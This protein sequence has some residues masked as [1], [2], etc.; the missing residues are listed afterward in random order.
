MFDVVNVI[1]VAAHHLS[2]TRPG[3]FAD[4]VLSTIKEQIANANTETTVTVIVTEEQTMTIDPGTWALY[5]GAGDLDVYIAAGFLAQI[6]EAVCANMTGTCNARMAD[7]RRLEEQQSEQQLQALAEANDQHPRRLAGST[8]VALTRNYDAA[9]P[10]A[11]V[12]VSTLV[13]ARMAAAG[14]SVASTEATSLSA[15]STVSAVGSTDAMASVIAGLT[16]ASLGA[17]LQQALP[18]VELS[19]VT[20]IQTPPAQPPLPTPPP[21]TPPGWPS[22]PP[23][24]NSSAASAEGNKGE[25]NIMI[26]VLALVSTVTIIGL[27][28]FLCTHAKQ[29]DAANAAAAQQ[30]QQT[31]TMGKTMGANASQEAAPAAAPASDADAGRMLPFGVTS[32]SIVLE[33]A[34]QPPLPVS[35]RQPLA[36]PSSASSLAVTARNLIEASAQEIEIV[37]RMVAKIVSRHPCCCRHQARRAKHHLGA[38]VQSSVATAVVLPRRRPC[39]GAHLSLTLSLPRSSSSPL[40]HTAGLALCSLARFA[41]RARCNGQPHAAHHADRDD[42]SDG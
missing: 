18:G 34:E 30:Q 37:K 11:A 5:D 6:K 40:S 2:R 41:V 22:L 14:V 38:S 28:V 1:S 10:N 20:R 17:A 7:T 24:P 42:A 12:D 19:V 33:K 32:L 25:T 39:R 31:S 29:K 21:P 16:D 23:S 26:A 15:E 9:S 8:D 3:A 36:T 27:L 4:A 13:A 35:A